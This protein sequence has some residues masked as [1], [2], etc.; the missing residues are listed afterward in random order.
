MLSRIPAFGSMAKMGYLKELKGPKKALLL[1]GI[2]VSP[3]R[4]CCEPPAR[5]PKKGLAHRV[6]LL[7]FGRH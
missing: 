4:F 2:I 3:S 1:P 5:V 6:S 7:Y